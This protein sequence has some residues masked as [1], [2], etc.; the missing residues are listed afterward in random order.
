MRTARRFSTESI[1]WLSILLTLVVALGSS[2]R[3]YA[4]TAGSSEGEVNRLREQAEKDLHDQKPA[5][6]ATEYQRL[7]TLQPDNMDARSNLGLAYYLQGNYPQASEEFRRVLGRKPDL[8]NIAALCGLSEAQ[9]GESVQAIAHLSEAFEQVREPSLLLATGTRLFSLL[10]S[11]GDLDGAAQVIEK[12]RQLHPDDIDVLYAAHQVHSLLADRAFRAMAQKAPNSARMYELQGDEMAQVGN[13]PGAI[14]AYRRA[15]AISPHLSGVHL[16]LAVVLGES[17]SAAERGQAESEY[18]EALE[19]NAQDERAECGLGN[20]EL[21]N[22]NLQNA[23]LHLQRALRLQPG[24]P[25]ANEELGIAL[26][27]SGANQEAIV[28]LTRAVR[29]DPMDGSAYY[30]LSLASRNAGD[31]EAARQ[32]MDEFLQIKTRNDEMERNFHSLLDAS[33]APT[34]RGKAVSSASRNGSQ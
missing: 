5:E 1:L 23:I 30:H 22:S 20:I 19:E 32:A 18:R 24:D 8:W 12:L 9:S 25:K 29:A 33:H 28:Y 11:S 7:L 34:T 10:M 2:P 26:M 16:A 14:L 17:H 6:A 27:R 15:I 4:Q 13:V 31:G 3:V 21:E